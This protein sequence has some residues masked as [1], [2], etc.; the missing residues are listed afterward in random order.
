MDADLLVV[1]YFKA[2]DASPLDL[3][4]RRRSPRG[5]RAQ[6]ATEAYD[7]GVVEERENIAQALILRLMTPRGSL[8]ALGHAA[9]G[10]LLYRLIGEL[11]TEAMRNLCR[12]YVLETV[13]QE[14]RVEPAAV[15]FTFD[16]AAETPSSLAFTLEVQ[17][18]LFDETVALDLE[19]L[20]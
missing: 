18:L 2:H 19:L 10:S 11:K 17:P 13:A 5:I 9:Y 3:T 14:P 20:L 7:L 16:R 12:A 6:G 15:A 1:P 4:L 8:A